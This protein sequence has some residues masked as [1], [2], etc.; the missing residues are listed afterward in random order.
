MFA[1]LVQT[2]PASQQSW[3]CGSEPP[4]QPRRWRIP[5]AIFADVFCVLVAESLQSPAC[6]RSAM[7]LLPVLAMAGMFKKKVRSF[8]FP[9]PYHSCPVMPLRWAD[10]CLQGHCGAYF[11]TEDPRAVV[12]LHCT[13]LSHMLNYRESQ[14]DSSL[15]NT[16]R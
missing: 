8:A 5:C 13:S 12:L 1:S 4:T 2:K 3:R 15:W 9:S 11:V 6:S 16:Q 7:P 14:T 10:I